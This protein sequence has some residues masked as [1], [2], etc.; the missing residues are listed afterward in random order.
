M[1]LLGKT[2]LLSLNFAWPLLFCLFNCSCTQKTLTTTTKSALFFYYRAENNLRQND[3][4]SA[5]ANLDSAI[6]YNPQLANFYRVKGFVLEK[7]ERPVDAIAAYQKGLAH[8]PSQPEIQEKLGNLYLSIGDF[9]NAAVNLKKASHANPDAAEIHFKLGKVFYKMDAFAFALNQFS[10][11]QSL[12]TTPDSAFWKWKGLALF[13]AKN[14]PAAAAALKKYL[15]PGR[16]DAEAI[17]ILGFAKFHIG[18]YD[19]A[20]SLLNQVEA[21]FKKDLQMY[22][23]RAKYF[24]IYGKPD[25]AYEQLSNAMVIDSTNADVWFELG[26]MDYHSGR[27]EKSKR[28]LSKVLLLDQEYWPAYRYLGFIAEKEHELE[29]AEA[30][31]KQY[32]DHTLERDAEVIERMEGIA[33]KLRVK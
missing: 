4:E 17:K 13:K 16:D 27:Y 22:R 29:K 18:D 7:L 32:L 20:I 23:Y 26:E 28:R 3:F 2:F 24:L 31:Y 14:Y 12:I 1:S 25:I 21:F 10:A 9:A 11:Y 15:A 5:L 19:E 30:Y 8:N 6:A 33:S